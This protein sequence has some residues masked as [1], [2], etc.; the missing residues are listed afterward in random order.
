MTCSKNDYLE[1][2]IKRIFDM[3]CALK[4]V[5]VDCDRTRAKFNFPDLPSEPL[6]GYVC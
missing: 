2:N 6:T 4:F 3:T 5:L 1:V